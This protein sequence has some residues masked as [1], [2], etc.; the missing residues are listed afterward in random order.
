LVQRAAQAVQSLPSLDA[1]RSN[2]ALRQVV[3]P[4]AGSDAQAR[5]TALRK[6]LAEVAALLR[7]GRY[8]EGRKRA[9]AVAVEARAVGYAPLQAEALIHR[10]KAEE[11]SGDAKAAFDTLLA[12][13]AASEAGRDDHARAEAL[14]RLVYE[15]G[16]PLARHAEAHGYYALAKAAIAR[17]GGDRVLDTQADRHEAMA[18][19][20]QAR[21][22]DSIRLLKSL[23]AR[24]EQLFGASDIE[25]GVTNVD[26]GEVYRE[27]G[28][29]EQAVSHFQRA[30]AILD[31]GYGPAHPLTGF[32]WN[33]LGG[34]LAQR[35][36]QWPAAIDALEKALAIR[37]AA[38]GPNHPDV[39]ATLNNLG[40]TYGLLGQYERALP[41]VERSYAIKVA[42]LGA[43]HLRTSA[44]ELTLAQ[45]YLHLNRLDA[46]LEH[47]EHALATREKVYGPDHPEVAEA[48]A[49]VG[50]VRV[51][52][53]QSAVAVKLLERALVILEHHPGQPGYLS[54]TQL[55]L[56][57]ALWDSG[58]DRR[59]ARAL[60]Q[61]AR[62]NA[63]TPAEVD[64]W[65]ATHR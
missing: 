20:G 53:R 8:A 47:A 45:L 51:S 38:L 11:R 64:G 30:I 29:I 33:N 19:N 44:S 63:D 18:L 13:V 56:A 32:A 35:K 1:C 61:A 12:A 27:T 55:T 40:L 58:G 65:L 17:A 62:P 22:D 26:I 10:G 23:L 5:V 4:P 36:D 57:Q 9:D 14:T 52:R 41:L 54:E 16:E 15:V 31:K 7:A 59:R 39:A 21:Y 28:D 2:E 6:R 37:E 49:A 25:V 50:K 24:E 3:R 46:A 34:T 42:S 48:L 43:D 60:A